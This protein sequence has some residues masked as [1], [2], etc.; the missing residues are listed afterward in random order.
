MCDDDVAALVIDNGSYMLKAGFVG[1][2]TPRAVFTVVGVPN[3]RVGQKDYVIGD[4]AL[5][6]I[7]DLH[8][9]KLPHS[10]RPRYRAHRD[11]L[12]RY[13]EGLLQ[14]ASYLLQRTSREPRGA[15]RSPD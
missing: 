5:D 1:D 15:P 4:E 8:D 2:D 11:Q 9:P 6:K 7:A 13:G 3:L 14:L 10:A 12:E